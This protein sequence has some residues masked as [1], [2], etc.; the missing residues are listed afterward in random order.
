MCK[1]IK[2][3]YRMFTCSGS[4][5]IESEST[6]TKVKLLCT[7]VYEGCEGFKTIYVQRFLWTLSGNFILCRLCATVFMP[8]G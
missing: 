4:V 6:R 5:F 8:Q 3:C 2:E 7:C 1:N